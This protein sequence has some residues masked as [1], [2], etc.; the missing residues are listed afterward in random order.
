MDTSFT[1]RDI[2]ATEGLK[3]HISNQTNQRSY[4]TFKGWFSTQGGN[5]N[6]C[7]RNKIYRP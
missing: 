2:E 7:E 6:P 4:D 5:H 3:D 1:F